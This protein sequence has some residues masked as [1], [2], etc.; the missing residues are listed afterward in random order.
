MLMSKLKA[1]LAVVLVLGF[2]ATGAT[3]LT[4]RAATTKEDKPPITEGQGIRT[5]KQG[6]Q[7]ESL[8]AS[9]QSGAKAPE[10]KG[11]QKPRGIKYE[12]FVELNHGG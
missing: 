1:A 7:K 12:D 10:A 8:I 9:N 5:Q 2:L 3:V 4:G 6:R 11:E